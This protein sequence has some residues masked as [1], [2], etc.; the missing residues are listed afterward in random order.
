MVITS[1]DNYRKR[2]T[3]KKLRDAVMKD[4]PSALRTRRIPEP[5]ATLIP[6][7]FQAD[8]DHRPTMKAVADCLADHLHGQEIDPVCILILFDDIFSLIMCLLCYVTVT[9]DNS[10]HWVFLCYQQ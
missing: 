1:L 6:Y 5:F 7:C 2:G 8:A 9:C 10:Q 3:N 4:I